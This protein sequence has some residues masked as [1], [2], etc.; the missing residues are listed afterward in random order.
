[1][2]TWDSNFT[3]HSNLYIHRHQNQ[4]MHQ[5][6]LAYWIH[7][8]KGHLF[9]LEKLGILYWSGIEKLTRIFYTSLENWWN[10]SKCSDCTFR[11]PSQSTI[12]LSSPSLNSSKYAWKRVFMVCLNP[13]LN[14]SSSLQLALI[15]AITP[16]L[17]LPWATP[18]SLI[19]WV[20][21][22]QA[23]RQTPFLISSDCNHNFLQIKLIWM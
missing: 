22:H 7:I 19:L 20:T 13:S 1:M 10:L 9:F 23:R 2:L 6:R 21:I 18:L 15:L 3:S 4:M 8:S 11:K 17:P 5:N 16:N 14:Y 12:L